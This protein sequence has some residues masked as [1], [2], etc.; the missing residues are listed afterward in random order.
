MALT[1]FSKKIYDVVQAIPFGKVTT[2]GAISLLSIKSPHAARAIAPTLRKVAAM[3]QTSD[4]CWHRVI[5]AKGYIVIKNPSFAKLQKEILENEGV[6][7]YQDHK[8]DLKVFGFWG[9]LSL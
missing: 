7:F 8:I 9:D 5:N 2:Y 3:E 4:V 6:V 1:S